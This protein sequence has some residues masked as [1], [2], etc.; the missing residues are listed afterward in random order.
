MNMSAESP[1]IKKPVD[2]A[3]FESFYPNLGGAVL[4]GIQAMGSTYIIEPQQQR[5]LTPVEREVGRDTKFVD[6][7]DEGQVTVAPG[8]KGRI[9]T[10]S[11]GGCTAVGVVATFPDG[12]RR[13]H[14]QH[15]D[16]FRKRREASDQSSLEEM[17]LGREAEEGG[18]EDAIR[19]DAAIM[20][21]GGGIHPVTTDTAHVEWLSTALRQNFGEE[22]R[23]NVAPYSMIKVSGE[24]LYAKALLIDIPAEGTPEIFPGMTRI[25]T[26]E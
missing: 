15:Y 10:F 13:A 23:V 17:I 8:E 22:T 9:A 19:I 26:D 12:T 20:V 6:M 25:R 5:T 2:P 4:N 1:Y 16:P 7:N 24:S 21:P 3:L 11:L 14:V 18:Y